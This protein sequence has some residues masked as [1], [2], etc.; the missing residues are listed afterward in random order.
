M[1]G[2]PTDDPR[3]VTWKVD[4]VATSV[5]VNQRFGRYGELVV[6]AV[7][8]QDGAD[9]VLLQVGDAAPLDLVAGDQRDVL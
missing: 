2:T 5:F 9:H 1:T 4:G 7:R 6:L 3:I 8:A